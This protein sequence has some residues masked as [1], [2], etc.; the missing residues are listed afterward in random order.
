[1]ESIRN[2]EHRG[3][4]GYY[5]HHWL[6]EIDDR[7]VTFR[8]KTPL[9]CSSWRYTFPK[10]YQQRLSAVDRVSF[11]F[12]DD[13]FQYREVVQLSEANVAAELDA[14]VRRYGV[15]PEWR[16]ALEKLRPNV[17]QR[18]KRVLKN[19]RRFRA[20]ADR[21]LGRR[22]VVADEEKFWASIPDHDS[23]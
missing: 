15:Y 4:P 21:L 6:V 8:F 12:W 7:F 3:Y 2:L 19:T 20:V 16:Y 22:I 5:H 18:V 1:M 17:R 23:R 11:L 13:S 9:L 14:F 10:S